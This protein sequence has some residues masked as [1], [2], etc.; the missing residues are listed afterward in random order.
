LV[1][2]KDLSMD[3]GH[4]EAKAVELLLVEHFKG[5]AS[6]L[7]HMDPC[8]ESL[9]PLCQQNECRWRTNRLVS[10][11]AWTKGHL[12]RTLSANGLM[13]LDKAARHK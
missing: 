7:V 4:T 6:V 2:P 3:R 13:S 5:N 9:C 1:L 11:P 12:V 10:M 8:D